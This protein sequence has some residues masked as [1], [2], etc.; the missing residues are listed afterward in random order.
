ME[1]F[2]YQNLKVIFINGN[3]KKEYWIVKNGKTKI[4]IVIADIIGNVF[5]NMII[6]NKY[7]HNYDK[8]RKISEKYYAD[9]KKYYK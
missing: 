9:N 3:K 1:N 2:K 6:M 5:S 8:Y 7:S 4:N